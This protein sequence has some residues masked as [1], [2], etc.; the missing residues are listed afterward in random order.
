MSA[1]PGLISGEFAGRYTVERE[2]GRGATSLVY[3]ARDH[4]YGRMVAIKVLRHELSQSVASDRFL[5]EVRITAQLHHPNIVPILHSGEHAGQLFFVLPYLDGGT[6]RER[7]QREKQLP[8]SEVVSIGRTIALA[9]ASAHERNTLHRDVKPENI[10]FTGGQA[11]LADFGIARALTPVTGESTT[12]TG[13]VLGT[14]AY[15]SPEQASGDRDYDGRSDIYSLA[16]VLYEAL[17]GVPAFVGA[18]TQSV[19]AQRLLY[20]PRPVRVYRA[21]VSSHLEAVLQRALAMAPADRYQSAREFADALSE[22]PTE[23]TSE[24][25]RV[26]RPRRWLFLTGAPLA[27]G[28]I[29]IALVQTGVTDRFSRDWTTLDTTRIAILPFDEAASGDV[30]AQALLN[31]SMRRWKGISLVESF[32]I[33]DAVRRYGVPSTGDKA[34]QISRRVGAGR[35]VRGRVVRRGSE[36]RVFALLIDTRTNRVLHEASVATTV[37]SVHSLAPFFDLGDS[38]ALRGLRSDTVSAMAASSRNLPAI[39]TMLQGMAALGEWNLSVAESLY[40]KALEYDP[41]SSRASFWTAQIRAWRSPQPEGWRDLALQATKDTSGLT[42]EER[43]LAVAL[44]SLAEGNY[45]RSCD[46]YSALTRRQPRSFAAW[47][48]LGQCI[49]LDHVVI[50]DPRAAS[51]WRFRSSYQRAIDAYLKAFE[52]LPSVYRAYQ[53]SAYSGLLRT[54]FV[55]GRTRRAGFSQ[56]PQMVFVAAPVLDGDTLVFVVNRA[57]DVAA[58]R[59]KEDPIRAAA[60]VARMRQVFHRITS[61]WAVAFPMSPGAKEGLALSLELRGDP[62]AVDTLRSA[63]RLATDQHQRLHLLASL[64]WTQLKFGL[65]DRLPLLQEARRSADSVL[66][67]KHPGDRNTTELLS[68]FAALTGR[69]SSAAEFSRESADIVRGP[70]PVIQS[71]VG[72]AQGRAA[73]AAL[74]CPIPDT[75]P[76]FD[77]LSKMAGLDRA[78][79]A[80]RAMAEI[81]LFGQETRM[82]DSLNV[83]SATRLSA[84]GDYLIA[85]R[86]AMHEGRRDEARARLKSIQERRIG[87]LRGDVTPDGI[88]PESKIWLGLGDTAAA[89]SWLDTVLNDV[90]FLQPMSEIELDNLVLI[91]STV[92]AAA[93]RAELGHDRRNSARWARAVLELWSDGDAPLQPMMRKMGSLARP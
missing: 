68:R 87:K 66:R 46:V 92:R 54:L 61:A 89:Q 44:A 26:S 71:V 76:S 47:F 12:S 69:C 21:S 39:Q 48:G 14:P 53:G 25:R 11:C 7:F 40:A 29:A 70:I 56:K 34:R 52:A 23:P 50:A 67:M 75:F 27:I 2:L 81:R 43:T 31:E 36:A 18:T 83:A 5:R 78:A 41:T 79:P 20:E 19:S 64:V 16:C 1:S 63:L 10:L 82:I 38:L 90:R 91:A 55:S 62:A 32:A 28:L 88:V 9:L 8:I 65:P 24:Q 77:A 72:F 37:D 60:A 49:D 4:E 80:M 15:M 73:Y 58:G 30:N 35:F 59:S 93:L 42:D 17:A 13:I 22:V 45:Q 3:L 57:T 51:G 84:A 6:L 85:A 74:G 86:L 33:G